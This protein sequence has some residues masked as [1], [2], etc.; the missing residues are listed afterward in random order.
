MQN[1][2]FGSFEV[3]ILIIVS[4]FDIRISGFPPPDMMGEGGYDMLWIM[5]S[6]VRGNLGCPKFKVQSSK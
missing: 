4:D 2:K 1:K 5:R 3:R 6:P